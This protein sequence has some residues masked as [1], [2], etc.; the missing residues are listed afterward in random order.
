M[1]QP[2][3]HPQGNQEVLPAPDQVLALLRTSPAEDQRI[4]ALI[5]LSARSVPLSLSLPPAAARA[6][7]WR[8]LVGGGEFSPGGGELSLELAPYQVAWLHAVDRA[9]A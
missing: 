9:G 4:L 6:G 1:S 7:T 5:N 8:D 3:F 2:A